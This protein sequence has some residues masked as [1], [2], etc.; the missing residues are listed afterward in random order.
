MEPFDKSSQQVITE[1]N[2]SVHGLDLSE[3]ETRQKAYG[4]NR[5]TSAPAPSLFSI[6]IKQFK[7]FIVYILLFAIFFSLLIGE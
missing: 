3:V 7:D 2:S 1:M 5:L 6:F 4:P